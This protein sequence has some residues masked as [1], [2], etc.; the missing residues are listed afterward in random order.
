MDG[1]I[2]STL[3]SEC[4]TKKIPEK[5]LLRYCYYYT[6]KT[7]EVGFLHYNWYGR[8]ERVVLENECSEATFDLVA[9]LQRFSEYDRESCR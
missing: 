6:T 4:A 3:P 8:Y 5:A 2:Y 1:W 7:E 9:I